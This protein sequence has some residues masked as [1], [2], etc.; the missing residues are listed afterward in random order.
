MNGEANKMA[1]VLFAFI[2][3]VLSVLFVLDDATG[4]GQILDPIEF[5]FMS[6]LGYIFGKKGGDI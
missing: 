2:V 1:I 5:M 6:V 4:I 3:L